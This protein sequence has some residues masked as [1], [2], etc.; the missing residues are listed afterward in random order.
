MQILKST[1]GQFIICVAISNLLSGIFSLLIW[2]PLTIRVLPPGHFLSPWGPMVLSI[3]MAIPI[4]SLISK[5]TAKPIQQMLECTQAIAKGDYS[6]RVSE[7]GSGDMAKLIHSFN[8]MTEELGNTELMR[9]DFIN[10]FSHEFKTPIVSIRGFAKRLRKGNISQEKQ[11][12]YLDFIADESLRLSD[13]ASNILLLSKYETQQKVVEKTMYDLDE[14]IRACVL[15]L[16]PQWTS[17]KIIF[18][19]DLKT[20]RYYGNSEM[21]EHVWM[22]L[23]TNAIKFSLDGATIHILA[24]CDDSTITVAIQDEGIG[25]HP[26]ALSHIFDKFYQEDASHTVGGNGLGLPLVKRIITLCDGSITVAS[27]PKQG[28]CFTV[29]LPCK[30]Q[31]LSVVRS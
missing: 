13:L 11:N 2:A 9:S 27:T 4:A 14:Q 29:T 12:E 24:Q 31:S 23:L 7:N 3:I 1:R 20:I 15:K 8:A 6:M 21:M 17:R 10:T 5:V 25:I 30:N 16:E 26:D 19:M 28:S 22:N 18:E